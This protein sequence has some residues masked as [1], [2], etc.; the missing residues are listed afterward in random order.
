[1]AYYIGRAGGSKEV[2]ILDFAKVAGLQ[3]PL[4]VVIMSARLGTRLKDF[5]TV[6]LTENQVRT[7]VNSKKF[8]DHYM[9]F[10][11]KKGEGK[12]VELVDKKEFKDSVIKKISGQVK[13]YVRSFKS[14]RRSQKGLGIRG[15]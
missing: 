7:L 13:G 15:C 9:V 2:E 4:N 8:S 11:R 12:I 5:E 3:T 1:M 6:Q 10:R 14:R